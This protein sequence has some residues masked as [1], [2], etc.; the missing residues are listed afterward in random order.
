ML[1]KGFRTSGAG[2]MF[3]HHLAEL[4]QEQTASFMQDYFAAGGE[5][6][7]V[8]EWL[9]IVGARLRRPTR[10]RVMATR[11]RRVPAK[12]G[13]RAKA[14]GFLGGFGDW[15]S[16]TVGSIVDSIGSIVDSVIK[17]GKSLASAIG[18]AVSWT[19][20]QLTD[21]VE[22]LVR[23]GKRVG[24]ILAAAATRGV[25]L[26][27]KYVEAVLAAGRSLTE[28]V[29]W[30]AGQ[31]AT[32]ANAVVSKLL[33]LGRSVLDIL[34]TVAAS[35]AAAV[36]AIVKAILAAGRSLATIMSVLVNQTFQLIRPIVQALLAAGKTLQA[37][38]V[39]AAKLVA[40]TAKVIV[41]A[42]LSLGHTLLQVLA[43]VAGIVGSTLRAIL[44]AVLALGYT[45]AQVLVA[46]AALTSTAVKAVVGALIGLGKTVASIVVAAVSLTV[47]VVKAV[48]TALIA[49]GYKV[50]AFLAALA[51]RA[52]SALRTALEALLAMGIT[53]ASLVSDIVLGVV[54]AFRRGFFEGLIALGKAPLEILKAAA[55]VSVAVAFLAATVVIELFGGHRP[56]SALERQAAQAVFGSSIDLNRVKIAIAS[57]PADIINYLNGDRPF[58][59]MYIINFGSDAVV[60]TQTLIHELTHVWQ[61]VQTGPLYMVRALEAQIGAG[62][63]SL[64][65]TGEYSDAAA[66]AVTT[67]DLKK[68]QGDFSK[69]NPEQQAIIVEDYW[70]QTFSGAPNAGLPSADLLEPYARQVFKPLTPFP[71]PHRAKARRTSPRAKS[72]TVRT[73]AAAA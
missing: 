62:V 42:L 27:K 17:A 71:I 2:V 8:V 36:T 6:S 9:R 3:I 43:T 59:T 69:F 31:I 7:S 35:S 64:F 19:V 47:S 54:A 57:L 45:L 4:P 1:I 38:L 33:Q 18:E 52:L 46:V 10:A 21:L 37:L 63:S 25:D 5:L 16:D 55:E 72:V 58:T 13:T 14:F 20:D 70:V 41:Q 65:H 32:S 39:E 11:G 40:A 61:G 44:G 50:A 30:A 22:A 12:R 15:I 28:V 26:L 49:L 56:L 73:R 34:K 68:H 48:F 24:D 67:S 29:L 23:A 53:L 66:Y 60:D 51:G